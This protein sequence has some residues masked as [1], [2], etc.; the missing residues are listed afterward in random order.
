MNIIAALI[1]VLTGAVLWSI[2][3]DAQ[4]DWRSSLLSAA[5]AW[6]M[7]LVAVTEI[8][9]LLELIAFRSLVGAWMLALL[10]SL[11]WAATSIGDPRKLL[12][13]FHLAGSFPV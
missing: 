2:F 1:P 8:L 7:Y 5:M 3:Y 11:G 13:R 12:A 4:Q 9:S 10:L 6:G